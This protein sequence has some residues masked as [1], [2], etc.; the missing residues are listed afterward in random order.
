MNISTSGDEYLFFRCLSVILEATDVTHTLFVCNVS[1][2]P[3]KTCLLESNFWYF[4]WF[5]LPSFSFIFPNVAWSH[6]EYK[7]QTTYNP[8]HTQCVSLRT[9]WILQAN[10]ML[11]KTW[12]ISQTNSSETW[13]CC[14]LKEDSDAAM[15]KADRWQPL[16]R[17]VLCGSIYQSSLLITYASFDWIS[18]LVLGI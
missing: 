11:C 8:I 7:H 18:G 4:F 6:F 3:V 1:V 16:K 14:K 5:L 15:S 13:D 12:P 2:P 17:C 10:D 9:I